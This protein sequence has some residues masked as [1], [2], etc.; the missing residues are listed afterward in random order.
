MKNIS[1]DDGPLMN[2]FGSRCDRP[3]TPSFGCH[4]MGGTW[5]DPA[6]IEGDVPLIRTKKIKGLACEGGVIVW[7][8][9]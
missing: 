6:L 1:G 7:L 2:E 5:E 9:D 8:V 4:Y 3:T